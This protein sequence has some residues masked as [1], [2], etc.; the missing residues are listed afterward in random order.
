GAVAAAPKAKASVVGGSGVPSGAYPWIVAMSR[1]CGGSLVAPDRVLTAAHCVE[2]LRVDSLGLYVGAQQR[3]RGS[4][5]YDGIPVRAVDVATHPGYRSLHGGGPANDVAVLQLSEPVQGVEPVRLATPEDAPL[6]AADNPALVLGWGV[7]RTD[8]R[9][10]PLARGL[11]SGQ[12]RLLSDRSCSRVYGGDGAYRPEVML[13]ARS[14]NAFRRP[15]TS[16][17]VGDSGGP[18]LAGGDVQ[19]GVV[20]FGISCG[21]LREPTVFSEVAGLRGFIDDPAPVWAPQPLGRPVV[22]GR[23]AP[24][25]V[26]TCEPPAFRNPVRRLRY[27][28][29]V[30]R[31]LVATGRRVRITP[32]AAGKVLQCRV[33]AE[34]DG[35]RTPTAASP[36][37]RVASG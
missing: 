37:I 15:N 9:D 21:A 31:L 22:A 7:T 13:C 14:R 12:L 30:N 16:P 5:R 1:G 34:N 8:R 26:V 29:G 32:S 6:Q 3:Q 20:S 28:W 33:V 25:E 24:G 27:R 4:L 17:C 35:G 23:I 2:D 10:P 36:I 11:R 18:L 19:I